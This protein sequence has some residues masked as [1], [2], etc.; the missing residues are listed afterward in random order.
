MGIK[1]WL[2]VGAG[3]LISAVC[4]IR[5]LQEEDRREKKLD[6]IIRAVDCGEPE[7]PKTVEEMTEEVDQAISDLD[8]EEEEMKTTT[9]EEV[10][11]RYQNMRAAK[12]EILD[13][14][15]PH[16]DTIMQDILEKQKEEENLAR[17]E[18]AVERKDFTQMYNLFE[19]R[20]NKYPVQMS[21]GEAFG[22]ARDEGL[23]T[24]D[25]LNEAHERYGK[26]WNYVGD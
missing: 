17:I 3:L 24:K 25:I 23:I 7:E 16:T 2:A 13:R 26:L 8:I 10:E 12:Q 20:Y 11:Q 21:R 6:R 14:I 9:F 4:L 19:Q 18:A 22:K 5:K 15:Q 1:G